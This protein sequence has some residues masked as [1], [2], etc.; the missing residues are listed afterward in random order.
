M[1]DDTKTYINLW[2]ART[3]LRDYALAKTR[4]KLH[5]V[6][7]GLEWP[8]TERSGGVWTFTTGKLND[9]T[10]GGHI[11]RFIPECSAPDVWCAMNRVGEPQGVVRLGLHDGP[12]DAGLLWL[13]VLAG[14]NLILYCPEGELG[15][16]RL[17]KPD[18]GLHHDWTSQEDVRRLASEITR[19]GVGVF[20]KVD[21]QDAEAITQALGGVYL[22][23]A[24]YKFDQH[25]M[26][27]LRQ[28]MVV[29]PGFPKIPPQDATLTVKG[30]KLI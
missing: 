2:P 5:A 10:P 1:P 26:L 20:E 12:L 11:R 9:L 29:I 22:A 23:P 19:A 4:E 16:G 21:I 15:P 17:V 6:S 8:W 25:M 27:Y 7:L 14:R 3:G 30:R 18:L 28:T 24:Y 13:E